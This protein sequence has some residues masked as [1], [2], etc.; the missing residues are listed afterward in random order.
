MYM[1]VQV[2][3]W[4]LMIDFRDLSRMV[5]IPFNPPKIGAESATDCE[6]FQELGTLRKTA[7]SA[8]YRLGNFS[9]KSV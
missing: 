2:Y 7:S 9:G 4:F 6:A 3:Y 5:V 8:I 1:M